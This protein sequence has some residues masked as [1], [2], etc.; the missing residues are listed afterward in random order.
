[1]KVVIDLINKKISDIIPDGMEIPEGV[2]DKNSSGTIE[3]DNPYKENGEFIDLTS[4]HLSPFSKRI[5]E[6]YTLNGV[7][8]LIPFMKDDADGIIQ[9]KIAFEMGVTSTIIHFTNGVHMPIT[10]DELTAFGVWFVNKRNEY[11]I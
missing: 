5:G 3:L 10:P 4:E 9:V 7:D 6:T 11:F 2:L 1:M 8:Y